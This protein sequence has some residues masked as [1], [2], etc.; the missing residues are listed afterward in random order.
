MTLEI[1]RNCVDLKKR[2]T[3][4]WIPSHVGLKYNEMVNKLAKEAVI[5][6]TSAQDVAFP[7]SNLK[8]FQKRKQHEEKQMKLLLNTTKASWYIEVYNL[9]FPN[10]HGTTRLNRGEIVNIIRACCSKQNPSS[11][12][13][14]FHFHSFEYKL[15]FRSH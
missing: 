15:Q 5:N 7:L 2:I 11:D 1:V 12:E 13:T 6:R 8:Y 4:Q 10:S 14:L 3:F 9:T